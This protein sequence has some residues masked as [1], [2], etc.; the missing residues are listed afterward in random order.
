MQNQDLFYLFII[1]G[2]D[3]IFSNYSTLL[4]VLLVIESFID[5]QVIIGVCFFHIVKRN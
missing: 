2:L 4:M 5:S 3:V 1:K